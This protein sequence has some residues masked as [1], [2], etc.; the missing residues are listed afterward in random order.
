M[1]KETFNRKGMDE[2]HIDNVG[3]FLIDRKNLNAYKM[4]GTPVRQGNPLWIC[5]H[6]DCIA[7]K[8]IDFA[9]HMVENHP[10]QAKPPKKNK[11]K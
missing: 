1:P 7:W 8:E 3:V 11:G 4:D 6:G 2:L 10:E 5:P 9:K